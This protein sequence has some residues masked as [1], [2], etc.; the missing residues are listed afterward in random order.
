MIMK[1]SKKYEKFT[2]KIRETLMKNL[3]NAVVLIFLLI[4]PSLI[5]YAIH[6]LIFNDPS[7]IM[8]DLLAQLAFLP[9]FYFFSTIVIEQVL[10]NREKGEM[11]KKINMLIGVYFSEMGTRLIEN[12]S[13]FDRDF[14]DLAKGMEKISTWSDKD[15]AVVKDNMQ[16]K[17]FDIDS[18]IGGLTKLREYIIPKRE[19]LV[20][21]MENQNLLEHETFTELTLA[22]FHLC[23]ELEFRDDLKSLPEADLDHL[24][25]D[26]KR[27]YVLLII[28]WVNYMKHLKEAYPYLYSLAVRVN[29]FTKEKNVVF[30][31]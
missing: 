7:Y 12:F 20:T 4:V 3:K 13:S 24:S 17:V 18:R 1:I 8:K 29:P 9:L 23:E 30:Y 26:I 15:F 5:I 6:L 10:T 22:V 21:L 31:K 19:F 25:G 16:K 27:A 2:G 11:I 14:E 28:E